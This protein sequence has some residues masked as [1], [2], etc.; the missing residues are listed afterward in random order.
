M[1]IDFTPRVW[2]RDHTHSYILLREEDGVGVFLTIEPGHVAIVRLERLGDGFT[3]HDGGHTW[4]LQPHRYDPSKAVNR[5]WISTLDKTQEAVDEMARFLG[6]EPHPTE[7]KEPEPKRKPVRRPKAEKR[8]I[9]EA[10]A[11]AEAKAASATAYTVQDMAEELGLE[12]TEVRKALRVG[13]VNKPGSRWEWED[14]EVAV[15]ATK[16]V[17]KWK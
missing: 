17:F 5:F 15:F 2:L 14:R 10:E 8:R 6:V 13:K 16:G 4:H 1:I 7:F 3:V 9:A 11:K 12:P